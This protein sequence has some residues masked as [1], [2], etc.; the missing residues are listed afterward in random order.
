MRIDL[1]EH[2]VTRLIGPVPDQAALHGYLR[3]VR[4][5]GM[6]LESVRMVDDDGNDR[7]KQTEE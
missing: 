2:G 6:V 4:D 3:S 7:Y 5:L 1:S